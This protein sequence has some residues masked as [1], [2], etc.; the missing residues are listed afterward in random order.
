MKTRQDKRPTL[1]DASAT[2]AFVHMHSGETA[3]GDEALLTQ[4]RAQHPDRQENYDDLAGLWQELD[5]YTADLPP[6]LLKRYR[7][8]TRLKRGSRRF[9]ARAVAASIALFLALL[10]GLHPLFHASPKPEHY[11]TG[12]G[13]QRS[14]NLADGSTVQLNSLTEL[15]VRFD[16]G[17]RA[18]QLPRGEALFTV[19]RD[20]QRPF[21]VATRNGVV[22]AV[23]TVFN[24]NTLPEEVIITVLDGT[25]MVSRRASE[26]DAKPEP[27]FA[28]GGRQVL[29]G[30]NTLR[31]TEASNL[32]QVMAWTRNKLIFSGEPLSQSLKKIN[33][34]SRHRLVV[35][36]S[37]LKTFPL[38]GVF[39]M[40][41]TAS[42]ILALEQT[43]PIKAI[44][45]SDEVTLLHY[46]EKKIIP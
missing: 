2:D 11:V 10:A 17:R 44:R 41:D 32:E 37:R 5:V 30:K 43:M 33:L 12:R 29:L 39:N 26:R 6:A 27:S 7:P 21:T 40:G 25:V 18:I 3:A 23:G 22:Q 8:D 35:E 38:Y 34:H 13:E 9:P 4:W 20:P 15:T 28:T 46:Q 31:A 19:A 1:G 42:L 45:V 24:I 36:D 14:I 16:N